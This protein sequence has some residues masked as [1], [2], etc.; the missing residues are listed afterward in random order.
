MKERLLSQNAFEEK[1][2]AEH[3]VIVLDAEGKFPKR[4]LILNRNGNKLE[5]RLIRTKNG[6]FILNK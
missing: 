5:Y 3:N 6:A 4:L 2:D 1:I